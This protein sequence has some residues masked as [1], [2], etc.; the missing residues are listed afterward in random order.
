MESKHGMPTARVVLSLSR[1]EEVGST[2][3]GEGVA[4]AH[5]R[6]KDLDRIQ[7]LTF[8]I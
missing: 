6:I 7:V 3:L 5:A 4:I 2:A 1:R 8:H